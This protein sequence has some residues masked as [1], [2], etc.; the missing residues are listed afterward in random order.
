[1]IEVRFHGRGGQGANIPFTAEAE[2][3]LHEKNLLIIPDFIANTNRCWPTRMKRAMTDR[4]CGTIG[5][6]SG[7]RFEP[8]GGGQSHENRTKLSLQTSW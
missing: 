6:M 7:A 1:M 4:R 5:R 2:R 8:I 3:I